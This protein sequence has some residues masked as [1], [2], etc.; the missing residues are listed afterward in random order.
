M[1]L[2]QMKSAQ[3]AM[4]STRSRII[5]Y[6]QKY[7]WN[8]KRHIDTIQIKKT[9]EHFFDKYEK[10]DYATFIFAPYP[11]FQKVLE[12]WSS[13]GDLTID[14]I[15]SNGRK[16]YIVITSDA[17]LNA[18]FHSIIQTSLYYKKQF[19][20]VAMVEA[21]PCF[22]CIDNEGFFYGINYCGGVNRLSSDFL[23]VVDIL[24]TIKHCQN[25]TISLN[26]S[27]YFYILV[28]FPPFFSI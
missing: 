13:F 2:N 27:N 21:V 25:G 15:G 12:F 6:L 3:R 1:N 5:L 9:Y 16:N 8:E 7:G 14:F 26:V 22:I 10:N 24:L 11:P 20:P 17:I 28:H 18:G 4:S 23:E 19:F